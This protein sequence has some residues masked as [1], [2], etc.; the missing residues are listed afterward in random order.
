MAS[1]RRLATVGLVSALVVLSAFLAGYVAASPLWNEPAPLRGVASA[2]AGEPLRLVSEALGIIQREFYDRSVLDS[3]KLAYGAIRG[4]LGALNDPYTFHATRRHAE[5]M[6]EDL[7]GSFGGIG[8]YVEIRD[9]KLLIVAPRPGTPAARAGL[10]PGDHITHVDGKPTEGLSLLDAVALIRGPVGTQVTLAIARQGGAVTLEMTIERAEIREELVTWQIWE[11][12]IAYLRLA[13]FG[14]VTPAFDSAVRE[15]L[16]QQPRGL[17]LDLRNNGGGYL[18]TAVEVASE[19][20]PQ[21]AVVLWQ[22]E[23]EGELKPM[24]VTSAGPAGQVPLAV[25]VNAGTASGAEIVAGA[26]RDHG[27]G[28]LVGERTFGKGSVQNIHSLSDGSSLRVTVA[29]FLTPQRHEINKVGLVPDLEVRSPP[30]LGEGS[31]D[32]A[33]DPPL[34]RAIEYLKAGRAALRFARG[35]I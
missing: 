33:S 8:A 27:R 2:Q 7:R 17:V 20:L 18:P 1:L 9:G 24:R 34:A 15:I 28:V 21:G 3:Q 11:D 5:M 16:A 4:L 26:L 30:A 32:P 35:V 25:L 19:F 6:E 23:A 12:G 31:G 10:M 22:Q 29:R 13:N 14:E